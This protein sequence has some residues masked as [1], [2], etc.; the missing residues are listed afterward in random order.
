M[1][2]FACEFA[3]FLSLPFWYVPLF[4]LK[5]CASCSHQKNQRRNDTDFFIR[6]NNHNNRDGDKVSDDI[7]KKI[8]FVQ[9]NFVSRNQQQH[10]ANNYS[11]NKHAGSRKRTHCQ[12]KI[13]RQHGCDV[14]SEVV[15]RYAQNRKIS[16]LQVKKFQENGKTAYARSGPPLPSGKIVIPATFSP[17]KSKHKTLQIIPKF[18]NKLRCRILAAASNAGTKNRLAVLSSNDASTS[19]QMMKRIADPATDELWQYANCR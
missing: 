15:Q 19:S 6:S 1:N 17:A 10:R 12:R 14:D 16:T 5:W 13:S 3:F 4:F 7:T 9:L 11:T 2:A 18:R 8:H